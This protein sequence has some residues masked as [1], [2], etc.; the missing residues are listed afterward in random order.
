[1]IN[2]S[3]ESCFMNRKLLQMTLGRLSSFALK[4][5]L[6]VSH[7]CSNPLDILAR[8]LF[9]Q[10]IYS[11]ILDTKIY[12]ENIIKDIL[13]RFGNIDYDTEVELASL[14]DEIGLTSDSVHSR[15]MIFTDHN[16]KLDTALKSQQR[17]SIKS[18]PAH[19]SLIIDYGPIRLKLR[20]DRLISFIS[21]GGFG[22]GSH[23][24]LSRDAELL[25]N[26]MIDNL[27]QFD[28]VGRMKL[29]GFLGHVIA[30]GIELMHS[31][32]K[33]PSLLRRGF[34][35]DF[36]SLHHSIDILDLCIYKCYAGGLTAL[37]PAPKDG[38][39]CFI[40]HL[41]GSPQA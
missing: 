20:L 18:F 33:R 36:E 12:T 27:L 22:Y 8:E 10:G 9:A 5:G 4:I 11:D 13:L 6:A 3:L 14:I 34:K 39:S 1:M 32:K 35:F 37:L 29:K 38:A 26:I 17:D 30:S 40:E 15:S 7:S 16:G 19:D 2:I 31:L 25:T 41:L 23:C 21:F 28:F 24:H